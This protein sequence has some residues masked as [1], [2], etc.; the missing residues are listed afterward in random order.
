M[1]L[2]AIKEWMFWGSLAIC[3]ANAASLA[4]KV[5]FRNGY[6][7]LAKT[8]SEEED[9]IVSDAE[10]ESEQETV[11]WTEQESDD[12]TEF[13]TEQKSETETTFTPSR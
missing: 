4:A 8:I 1:P 6:P 12:E 3:S 7:S 9:G 2:V 11:S 5:G 13:W 10:A